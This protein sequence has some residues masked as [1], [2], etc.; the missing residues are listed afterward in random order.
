VIKFT[1]FLERDGLLVFSMQN[2]RW[3][4]GVDHIDVVT[5]ATSDVGDLLAAQIRF[6]PSDSLSV[7]KVASCMGMSFD[8]TFLEQLVNF[9][10]T[11][12]IENGNEDAAKAMMNERLEVTM[13]SRYEGT[14]WDSTIENTC[15]KSRCPSERVPRHDEVVQSQV[16]SLG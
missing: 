3:E 15:T 9:S 13:E 14:I 5:M 16:A 1:V 8:D 12:D 2:Y 10:S 6:L 11:E 7:L 4:W